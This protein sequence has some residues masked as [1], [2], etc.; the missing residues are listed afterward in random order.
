M[1]DSATSR[2]PRDT[3]N[4]E[5]A[6]SREHS[7]LKLRSLKLG[8]IRGAVECMFVRKLEHIGN[9]V[10]LERKEFVMVVTWSIISDE[11]FK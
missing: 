4:G 3:K 9:T 2:E 5:S 11:R 6:K 8:T 7:L 10:C 1:T